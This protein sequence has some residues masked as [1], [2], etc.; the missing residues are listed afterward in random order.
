M[1]KK[2]GVFTV[3]LPPALEEFVRVMAEERGY[4]SI[5]KVIELALWKFKE[6]EDRKKLLSKLAGGE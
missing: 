5:S 6:E 2:Q 1:A 3:R 4:G